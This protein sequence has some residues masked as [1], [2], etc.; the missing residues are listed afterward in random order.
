MAVNRGIVYFEHVTGFRF[1]EPCFEMPA[2][3]TCHSKSSGSGQMPMKEEW[4]SW[5]W[6][7]PTRLGWRLPTKSLP[8][9]W[10]VRASCWESYQIAFGSAVKITASCLPIKFDWAHN[11]VGC[12]L[13]DLESG[14]LPPWSV[15]FIKGWRRSLA[16]L[17]CLEGVRSLGVELAELTDNFKDK[18]FDFGCQWVRPD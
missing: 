16:M 5:V 9:L 14:I 1:N 13:K 8:R 12:C 3:V 4:K 11:E 7:S 18:G 6:P 10:K 2:A 17:I 15:G